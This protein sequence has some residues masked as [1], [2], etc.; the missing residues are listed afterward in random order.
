MNNGDVFGFRMPPLLGTPQAPTVDRSTHR[1]REIEIKQVSGGFIVRLVG[2]G[3]EWH[4]RVAT[5][6]DVLVGI[7]RGFFNG[8]LD[9]KET[10]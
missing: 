5:N 6:E 7:V 4:Q 3:T 10:P 9:A 8:T 1:E 2:G